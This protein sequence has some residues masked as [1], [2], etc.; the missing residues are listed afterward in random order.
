MGE[1]RRPLGPPKADKADKNRFASYI[2]KVF[3]VLCALHAFRDGDPLQSNSMAKVPAPETKS[4]TPSVHNRYICTVLV[5]SGRI[6]RYITGFFFENVPPNPSVQEK[7]VHKRYIIGTYVQLL[8]CISTDHCSQ[9]YFFNRTPPVEQKRTTKNKTDRICPNLS[10][11][12][13]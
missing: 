9:P 2:C 12:V 6:I 7:S 8:V 1:A 4:G 11:N 5:W 10:Q 3:V 13:F